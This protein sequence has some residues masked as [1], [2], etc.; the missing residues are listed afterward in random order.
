[1]PV[2][3]K[4][5]FRGAAST[6]NTTLYTAPNTSTSFIVTH[7]AVTNT[8]SADRAF[9]LSIGGTV[10]AQT[11][12]VGG[13]DTSL[14]DLKTVVPASNPALTI[15]GSATSTNVNFHI[16]GVEIS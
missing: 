14:F 13:Y 7:I 11:V 5:F 3:Q 1:M 9:S 2:T 16:S 8:D 4:L 12:T 15:T 6:S 10:F